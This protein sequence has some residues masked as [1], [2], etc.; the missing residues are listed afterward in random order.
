MALFAKKVLLYEF[1]LAHYHN[2][3]LVFK[4][5]NA[6]SD[7]DDESV[8]KIAYLYYFDQL[9][10]NVGPPVCERFWQQIG[11]RAAQGTEACKTDN[12]PQ[13]PA[14]TEFQVV[15]T[16]P[17]GKHVLAT[18]KLVSKNN[19]PFIEATFSPITY[20]N[21]EMTVMAGCEGLFVHLFNSMHPVG[22][23]LLAFSAFFQASWYEE[24][25]CPSVRQLSAAPS[26]GMNRT[27]E[28]RQAQEE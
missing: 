21:T 15:S 14:Q 4:G 11:Q 12:D 28:L 19:N 23:M 24:N 26:Y 1:T 9:V 25:G 2:R 8:L 17:E 7:A 13:H 16:P 22:R 3:R 20:P 18:V 5:K 6:T 27:V 10:Y